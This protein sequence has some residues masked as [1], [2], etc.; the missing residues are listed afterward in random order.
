MSLIPGSPSLPK[1]LIPYLSVYPTKSTAGGTITVK[2]D[3]NKISP[4]QGIQLFSVTGTE[5]DYE[6]SLDSKEF[7]YTAPAT[8]PP[9]MYILV[10]YFKEGIHSKKI[11]IE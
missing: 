6:E 8:L 3:D 10:M 4:L 1:N 2:V 9:G 11:I 5:M 7:V